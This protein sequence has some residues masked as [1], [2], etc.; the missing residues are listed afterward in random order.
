[1]TNQLRPFIRSKRTLAGGAALIC[2]ALAFALAPSGARSQLGAARTETLSPASVAAEAPLRAVDPRGDAF[3]P[4][5]QIEDDRPPGIRVPLAAA[6]PRLPGSA[7]AQRG[8]PQAARITAIATG[9]QPT[10]IV[11]AGGSAHVVTVGDAVDGSPVAMISTTFVQLANGRRLP[12][13]AAAAQ[14]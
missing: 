8:A 5:A 13:E 10:A 1:M 2:Y 6:L 12:L 14:P 9:L 7:L 11:E 4:R 3:A